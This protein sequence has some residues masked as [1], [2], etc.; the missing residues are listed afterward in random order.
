MQTVIM[1]ADTLIKLNKADVIGVV[2]N[3]FNCIIPEVVYKEAIVDGK[4]RGYED[5][6]DLEAALRN[7]GKVRAVVHSKDATAILES[8]T[9]LGKGEKTCLHLYFETRASIIATDDW[10]FIKLLKANAIPFTFSVMIIIDLTRLKRI[11]KSTAHTAMDKISPLI[12]REWY[13][14]ASNILKSI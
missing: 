2:L 14:E 13:L 5:A 4:R 7:Q 10:R 9:S 3:T 8:A 12:K 11:S 6:A 1:D